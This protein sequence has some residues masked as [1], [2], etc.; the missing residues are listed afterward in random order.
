MIKYSLSFK[1]PNLG[2][3]D[4]SLPKSMAFFSRHVIYA[5]SNPI[6]I[7]LVGPVITFVSKPADSGNNHPESIL[8][9]E[10]F[11]TF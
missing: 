9:Y 3:I 8:K 10:I 6:Y 2:P 5:Q 11:L 4:A 1:N 7:E